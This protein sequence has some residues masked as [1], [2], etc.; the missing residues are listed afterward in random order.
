MRRAA[1][2]V[3]R[4]LIEGELALDLKELIEIAAAAYSGGSLKIDD[5]TTAQ[6]FAFCAER[7]TAYYAAK[8]FS[9]EEITAVAVRNPTSPLDFDHRVRAVSAF[10]KLPAASSLAAANKRIGNILRRADQVIPDRVD[11]GCLTDTAEQDLNKA[12]IKIKDEV[13]TK[14]SNQAYQDGL[15]QLAQLR[16]SI[17]RFFDDVMVMTDDPKLR[18]NRLALLQQIHELFLEVA[19]ISQLQVTADD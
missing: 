9:A 7:L 12:F 1:L 8:D 14:F 15:I 6:V 13:H 10:R 4:I 19:D 16:R 18:A 17:D 11:P 3:L 2:G 5:A